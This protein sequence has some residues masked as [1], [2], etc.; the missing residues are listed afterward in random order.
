MPREDDVDTFFGFDFDPY[1]AEPSD[2]INPV[3]EIGSLPL[4]FA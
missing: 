1:V 4:I 3:A 2:A